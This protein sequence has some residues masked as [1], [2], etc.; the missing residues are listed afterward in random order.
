MNRKNNFMIRLTDDEKKRFSNAAWL[1][2]ISLS[3]FFRKCA[4]E[5]LGGEK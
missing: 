4:N 3:E 2:R 1:R 5:I